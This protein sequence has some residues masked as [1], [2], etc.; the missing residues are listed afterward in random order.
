MSEL[1]KVISQQLVG[2][3]QFSIVPKMSIR[4]LGEIL[5]GGISDLDS[6][7]V[8]GGSFYPKLSSEISISNSRN[9]DRA[10]TR[11]H[12]QW[13][14]WM[15]LFLTV[16]TSMILELSSSSRVVFRT[17][18]WILS[19]SSRI[20]F[21]TTQWILIP[22]TNLLKWRIRVPLAHPTLQFNEFTRRKV[23]S[24][25]L[26]VFSVTNALCSVHLR[27]SW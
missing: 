19:S 22:M 18:Q 7:M 5:T 3:E 6:N 26:S 14:T 10:L 23:T 13:R 8:I 1:Q 16:F 27:I 25:L 9:S 2:V 11:L 24:S 17:T 4:L 21:R 12:F 15:E 20:V